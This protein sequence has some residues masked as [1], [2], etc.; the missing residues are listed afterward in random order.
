MSTTVSWYINRFKS[1]SG[2]ELIFRLGQ[3]CKTRIDKG[4]IGRKFSPS[5]FHTSLI[6]LLYIENTEDLYFDPV[7]NIFGITLD[8]KE[9]KIWNLDVSSGKKFPNTYSPFINIRND[10]YGSAKH[11]WE[12]NRMLFLP[13]LALEY[14]K[15]KNTETLSLIVSLLTSWI[16]QNLYLSG[17]N[18]YSNIEV[19]IRLINWVLTWDILNIDELI[20]HDT[21]LRNFVN[22]KWIPCIYSHCI[23][24]Y[25]NPSL[26]SSANNHLISEYAGL[27][28]ANCK[29][30]FPES[31]KWLAYSKRGLEKEIDL[32]HSENGINKEE[33]AKYIQFIADFLLLCLIIGQK[34]GNGLSS[35][36]ESRFHC[37][38]G[39]INE[40]LDVKGGVP[41]YG[42][43]DDG[44][45]FILDPRKELNLFY[46]LLRSGA[47]YFKD[48]SIL[49]IV[50][51]LDQKNILLFGKERCELILHDYN[52]KFIP[53][54]SKAF[55]KEGHFIFRLQESRSEEVYFHFD[56]APLGYLSIA[57]HGHSDALSFI[58][59]IN[60]L[61]FLIDPGTYCYH[62]DPEWRR[63][64]L[65]SKAHNT[66]TV[67]NENQAAYVGPTLWLDHYRS[68]VND[69]GINDKYDFVIAEHNGYRKF[70]VKH[71]RKVEFF[72]LKKQIVITD[73]IVN[74]DNKDLLIEMPFHINPKVEYKLSQNTLTLNSETN[75]TVLVILDE[76]LTWEIYEGELSP[77]MG[78]YSSSFYEKVPAPVCLGSI[79]RSS[80]LRLITILN[81]Y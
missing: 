56:A 80:S 59:H 76:Q 43:D 25:S 33:T 74:S 5:S 12:L 4:E 18:W 78:W 55:S 3:I 69:F 37:I 71:Q 28:V 60:G 77:I 64:F 19:N 61:P 45:V 35:S 22:D 67:N 40:L 52:N 58:L 62:T 36:F 30:T 24:S 8:P 26:Y 41:R 27:F 14:R 50:T 15:F 65:S 2:E 10:R 53:K 7:I 9:I 32:Q 11:V 63:Y 17:I 31:E 42:D 68:K 70:N 57:A 79:K 51:A 16:E 47:V 73:Q 20:F 23:F 34:S 81:I 66:I 72:K 54:S 6:Q 13:Q 1:L 39:Y 49:P 48:V 44:R 21:C 75:K 46:S 38:L 29:W